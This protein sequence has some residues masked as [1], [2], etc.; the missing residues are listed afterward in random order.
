MVVVRFYKMSIPTPWKVI[1]RAWIISGTTHFR[2]RGLQYA[3]R[4]RIIVEILYR[5]IYCK[6]MLTK[7]IGCC[8]RVTKLHY[9]ERVLHIGKSVTIKGLNILDKNIL[10]MTFLI[11]I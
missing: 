9:L 2:I 4:R 3:Q 10:I 11:F 8:I 7:V 5:S 6:K 1:G